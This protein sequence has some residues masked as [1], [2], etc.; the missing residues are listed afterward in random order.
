[1][2]SSQLSSKLGACHPFQ[3]QRVQ[4]QHKGQI[5]SQTVISS[6][7]QN[8]ALTDLEKLGQ[9]LVCAISRG[10]LLQKDAVLAFCEQINKPLQIVNGISYIDLALRWR[11]QDGQEQRRWYPDALTETLML[12]SRFLEDIPPKQAWAAIKAFFKACALTG[13]L[14]PKSIT[15]LIDAIALQAEQNIPMFL[16][17][18]ATRKNISH[19][20]KID[21]W[22]RL[23]NAKPNSQPSIPP[24]KEETHIIN[25]E[26]F[27]AFGNNNWYYDIKS[28]L[29]E[30]SQKTALEKLNAI[31]FISQTI[32]LANL[33]RDWAKHLINHGSKH[34]KRLTISTVRNYVSRV[35]F[36]LYGSIGYKDITTFDTQMF[37][38]VYVQILEDENKSRRDIARILREFHHY[39]TIKHLAPK[40]DYSILGAGNALCPVDANIIN[41]EEY[42]NTLD[43]IDNSD[44][45]IKHLDLPLIAKI[46]TILAFKCGLRRSEVLKLRLIDIQGDMASELLIRPHATRRLKTQSSKRRILL[47]LLLNKPEYKQLLDWVS[48]RSE[49]ERKK[50]YSKYLFSIPE[51][52]YAFVPE[53]LIFPAIHRALRQATGDDSLRFH[54]LR[55]S[56]ASWHLLQLVAT[57]QGIPVKFFHAMPKTLSWLQH[58]KLHE[59]LYAHSKSSK[60]H[61]YAISLMLGHASPAVTLEHY[62]HWCDIMLHHALEKELQPID[63]KIWV[64]ACGI[65]QATVYRLMRNGGE[66]ALLKQL[67]KANAN[68]CLPLQKRQRVKQTITTDIT[69]TAY[70]IMLRAWKLLYQFSTKNISLT[71]LADRYG[72]TRNE[73]KRMVKFA[74][75]L[76]QKRRKGRHQS[77]RYK[78]MTS[79]S[80]D[81][82]LCPR[83]PTTHDGEILAEDF[84]QKLEQLSKSHYDHYQF[85]NTTVLDTI[86]S[87]SNQFVFKNSVYARLFLKTLKRMNISTQYIKIEWL[88]GSSIK[89]RTNS[90]RKQY[91]EKELSIP[92]NQPFK[93]K[94]INKTRPLGENGRVGFQ[95]ENY[96]NANA[97]PQSTEAF[98]FALMMQSIL[99]YT[100]KTGGQKITRTDIDFKQG[101]YTKS[102]SQEPPLP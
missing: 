86:K 55:H 38:D 33:L 21:T 24:V 2:R 64:K 47:Y 75:H 87:S 8:I 100:F 96:L 23:Q 31:E 89:G 90:S 80:G 48:K 72:F 77:Y 41:I 61:L 44:L 6:I 97:S 88:Y 56:C 13:V 53:E 17:G 15:K 63:K 66:Q 30:K 28:A 7:N 52:Q 98:R 45:D 68:Q 59:K 3:P 51:L 20:L 10:G 82:L 27:D 79:E 16:A 94:K 18:Y 93:S 54:N 62:I 22:L 57:K 67:R 37:E 74:E 58:S 4:N 101:T 40:L 5:W 36:R 49:Q 42:L 84:A 91:W 95:I 25:E 14:A 26:T 83:K 34:T 73:A 12:K 76:E 35:S 46:I 39:L 32:P 69:N 85:L 65:P 60:K 70:P 92:K 78:L 43:H 102:F 81:R 1:M 29:N 19:S 99:N 11:G 50:P 71:D 9:I